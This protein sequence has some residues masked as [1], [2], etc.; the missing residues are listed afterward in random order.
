MVGVGSCEV[1][2]SIERW[3]SDAIKSHVRPEVVHEVLLCR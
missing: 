3:P 1:G 2:A